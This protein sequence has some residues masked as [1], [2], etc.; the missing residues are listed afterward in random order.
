MSD[1]IPGKERHFLRLNG[2]WQEPH[3]AAY[4]VWYITKSDLVD[5]RSAIQLALS[6]LFGPVGL[7]L[8]GGTPEEVEVAIS[9]SRIMFENQV[10]HARSFIETIATEHA[11]PAPAVPSQGANGYDTNGSSPL[12]S[13]SS[14]EEIDDVIPMD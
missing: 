10:D 13:V 5:V 4:A 2:S 9:R 7:A 14:L 12:Q 1:S 8:K 3:L 11:A 6:C